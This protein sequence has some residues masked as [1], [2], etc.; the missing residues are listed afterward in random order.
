[1]WGSSGLR[2]G[3]ARAW[4]RCL[5]QIFFVWMM[6]PLLVLSLYPALTSQ[7]FHAYHWPKA[8]WLY[9]SIAQ[10]LLFTGFIYGR[11][12]SVFGTPPRGIVGAFSAPVL[13]T[14]FLY[15]LSH[16]PNLQTNE[17]GMTA[18]YVAF[19]LLYSFLGFAWMLNI[20]RWTGSVWPGV[21]NHVLV[22]FLATI[23]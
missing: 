10:E 21:L 6:P 16:W 22:N 11:L 14:A 17:H 18:S 23:I 20:R 1:A 7:P 3:D 15:A 12:V 13:V 4:S 8:W 9:G 2:L 5:Y 19:Q